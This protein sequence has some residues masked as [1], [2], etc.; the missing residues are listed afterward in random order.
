MATGQ[1]AAA[2]NRQ[3]LV[4]RKANFCPAAN[5]E[6]KGKSQSLPENTTYPFPAGIWNSSNLCVHG[7]RV[8]LIRV[9]IGI[10]VR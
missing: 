4:L 7:I 2:S 5:G 9:S 3:P 10:R 1:P 6:Q 8:S